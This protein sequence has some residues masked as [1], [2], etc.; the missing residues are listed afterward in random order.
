MLILP[1]TYTTFDD[2]EVTETFTFHLSKPEIAELELERSE[3]MENFLRR[4]I[5]I[6][7]KKALFEE[8][9]K[10][11]LLSYGEKSP[12]GKRFVKSAEL[13][14]AFSQSA[15]YQE[16]FFQLLSDNGEKLAEFIKGIMP[17]DIREEIEKQEAQR[18]TETQ[19]LPPPLSHDHETGYTA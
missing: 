16:L 2:E 19:T 1:I 10:V 9:K 5:R 15:A 11:I 3:G 7:D 4:I 13:R 12:D 17:K 14:E 8:F 18:T 6:E